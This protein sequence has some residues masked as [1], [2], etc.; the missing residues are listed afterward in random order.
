MTGDLRIGQLDSTEGVYLR[1]QR[2]VGEDEYVSRFYTHGETGAASIQSM[3]GSTAVNYMYLKADETAFRQAVSINSGGTGAKNA[4]DARANLGVLALSGGTLTGTLNIGS[5]TNTSNNY[6]NIN[7]TLNNIV[8]TTRVYNAS[9]DGSACV[10][11]INNESGSAETINRM[12]LSSTETSFM[13]P[14]NIAGG[15]T[16]ATT[17]KQARENLGITPAN[18]GAATTAQYNSISALVGDTAVS[19]QISNYAPSKT[20]SGASG[21]WGINVTGSSASCTGNAATAS[22]FNSARSIELS[23]AVYGTVSSNGAS[24]WSINTTIAEKAIGPTNFTSTF[25]TQTKGDTAN[26]AYLSVIRNDAEDSW[27]CMPRYG[28]GIA[29][30]KW[31]THT[32]LYTHYTDPAAYI[33]GG[34]GDNLHWVRRLAFTDGTGASGTWGISITG[35][36]S[37]ITGTLGV[38][39]GGTGATT[40]AQARTNLGI[41]PANIGAATTAQFNN[42]TSLVGDTAVST[43]ISN[44]APSKAGSGAYGTWGINVT[45]SSGS[46]TGNAAT[47][48]TLSATLAVNKGGTGS[49]TAAGARTNLGICGAITHGTGDPSGGSD[50]DIYFKHA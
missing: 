21:N 32:Y 49:T 37:T 22:A 12:R 6:F 19:T 47:A 23:G 2:L 31:D 1:M 33:G 27:G 5:E 11:L 16:G 50:G 4:A 13:K 45:G 30:G 7:R 35:S 46:C 34:A 8:Y 29:F 28:T 44:Y 39:N 41:T 48:T 25:R 14:V 26:G 40:A 10:S 15:G 36:A 18:I 3:K 20:G 17:A 38:G 43:Q 24:G 9:T 42:L